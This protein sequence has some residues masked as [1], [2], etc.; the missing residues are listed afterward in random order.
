MI[1]F[2]ITYDN[3]IVS[4]EEMDH[5]HMSNI[6]YYINNIVPYFYNDEVR[7][8]IKKWLVKRFSGVILPYHPV[9]DFQFEKSHLKRMGYLQPNNDIVVGGIKIGCYE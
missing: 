3:R 1:N 4:M 2:W 6:H 7:K 9:P 8:H 5:Q